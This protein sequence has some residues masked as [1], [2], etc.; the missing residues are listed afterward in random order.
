[1]FFIQCAISRFT[2]VQ[3]LQG[4]A[5][6]DRIHQ[7]VSVDV[8]TKAFA[9]FALT[10]SLR[11]QRSTSEGQASGIGKSLKQVFTQV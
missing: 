11:Q 3:N 5:I 9:G 2:L 10:V 6:L 4:G 8:L 1:M 7:P